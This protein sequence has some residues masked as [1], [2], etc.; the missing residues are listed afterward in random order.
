MT[1]R[2]DIVI[3]G[4]GIM[5]CSIAYYLAQRNAGNIIVLERDRIGRGSTAAAAGGVRLQFSTPTNIELSLASFEVWENFESL[6]GVDLGLHQQGYLM[7][8]TDESEVETFQRNVALQQTFG[9]PSR[10]LD[11][12][13]TRE[14][15]PAVRVDDV[16]GATFCARDGWADPYTATMGFA[17]AA[18]DLGVEIRERTSV[19]GITRDGDRVTGVAA[20]GDIRIDAGLIIACAG[21]YTNQVGAMAGVEIP[22]LPYRRMSFTTRPFD[23]VPSWV[24]FTIDFATG[25]YFHPDGPCFLFGM[26]DPD[27]P[28]SLNLEVDEAWMLR[29]IEALCDRAPAFERATVQAGWAGFY[30]VTPDHNPVLGYVEERPGLVVAAGFSGHGFMQGPAIGMCLSELILDGASR[31]I[32]ISEF[33][34]SRFREGRLAT[35]HNVI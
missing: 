33:R 10:W 2:A 23:S 13:E 29:T 28:S 18:R 16:L 11:V 1:E 5:G 35:E 21:P 34:P 20:S 7:L 25:L 3:I 31:T 12:D 14:L 22:V 9:V 15:N 24:P 19:T 30:E 6:F 4:A 26:A 27:E 32:D 8:I 17:R